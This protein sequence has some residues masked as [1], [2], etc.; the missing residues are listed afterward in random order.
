MK[1]SALKAG[2]EYN[3]IKKRETEQ[4]AASVIQ[5][6]GFLTVVSIVTFGSLTEAYMKFFT[7]NF[8]IIRFQISEVLY[9]QKMK[10]IR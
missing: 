9:K 10:I 8:L 7:S 2:S 6:G 5:P 4:K 1:E 3:F